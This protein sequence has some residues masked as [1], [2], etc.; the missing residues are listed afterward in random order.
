MKK[1]TEKQIEREIERRNSVF[2][3][4][5]NAQKR[6]LIAKDVLKQITDRR[7]KPTRGFYVSINDDW[8]FYAESFR[9]RFI[10]KDIRSC[11]CCG[12]GALMVSCTLFNNRQKVGDPELGCDLGMAIRDND[13]IPNG[14]NR[15]FSRDQLSM[16][17]QAFECGCGEFGDKCVA[18]VEFG[19]RYKSAISRLRAIMKNIIHNK[20]TFVP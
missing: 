17:E 18:A 1:L 16:V 8:R 5:S 13:N 15:F 7:I 9:E 2:K 14:L 3:K 20:G 12:V 19:R 4:A 6:V 10:S 11:D